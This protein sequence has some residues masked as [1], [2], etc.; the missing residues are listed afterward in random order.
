MKSV[1]LRIL[2]GFGANRVVVEPGW[3]L[4]RDIGYVTNLAKA[5][6]AT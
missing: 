6:S 4:I 5:S 1:I 3:S 2:V